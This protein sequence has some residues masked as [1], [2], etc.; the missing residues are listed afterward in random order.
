MSTVT[1]VS[2][3]N[4]AQTI[5]QDTVDPGVRWPVLELQDWLNDSYREIVNARPDA[6]SQSG[7]FTCAIGTRQVLTT[8]FASA[9]RL[10]DVVRNTATTSAKKAIRQLD[11]SV[12]D[13]QRRGWHAETGKVDIEYFMFDPRLPREFLVYPPAATGAE[14]EVV[15]SLV[16]EGHTLTEAQLTSSPSTET[17]KLVDSYANIML[18]YMLYRAYSKDA[19][20]AANAARAQSHFQAMQNALGIKTTSDTATNPQD[21]GDKTIR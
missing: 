7:D 20:Y 14:I 16:P 10:I 1:V 6:N 4:R 2:L 11:R 9:L 13:D 5:L 15:Y 8:Q 17:I 3:V 21:I 18:D 19:E 12:L